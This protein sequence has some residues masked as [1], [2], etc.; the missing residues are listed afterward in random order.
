MTGSDPGGVA[1]AGAPVDAGAPADAGTGAQQPSG[2][3]PVARRVHRFLVPG[4]LVLATVLGIA[5]TFAI[6][7][8]RQALNT[9]NWSS[10]SS[11]ILQDKKVQTALSA[12][13]VHELFANVDVS[14]QLQ[15]V[16]PKQLQPLSGPAA[17]GLQQLAGQL[18]P[19]VL[20]S[21][22]VQG[23]WVQAN[24]AAHRELLRVLN[25]GGPVV[26]TRSGVVSL[27]LH[28]LV[29][30]LAAAVGLSSQVAAVQSKLQGST[31]ATVRAAAQQKLGVTLPPAS[32]QLVIMRSNEL[33]SA[34]DIAN[35]VKSLAIVLPA[36]AIGLFALA[37]Y[38]A[39]GRRRHTLRTTGWC[40]V[41]IGVALLLIRRVAGDAVVNGLVKIP[42]NKP[43]AH[44]VWNIG[45]SLLRDIA[46]AMIAYGIV[47][48]A[49]AWLA[50][51][52]RPGHRDPK[53]P[54][55]I[56]AR[57]SRG[58]LLDRR[59]PV[60]AARADRSDTGIPE[61]RLGA[62]VR[63]AARVRRHDA[64]TPDRTRV[65]W[66][67]ARPIATRLPRA[68]SRSP[69]TQDST[70]ASTPGDRRGSRR[71]TGG[72]RRACSVQRA[73][74]HAGAI[75]SAQIQ[76][77]ADRWGV[78]SR[79]G[80]H[81]EQRHLTERKAMAMAT[82]TR[83]TA[84]L[85]GR[86]AGAAVPHLSVAE[87]VARGKAARKE[88]PRAG[89]ALFEPLST[90]ADPVELLERQAKTRVP[91]LVPIRYGR[92][93]VSPFTFYRG[94]ASIMAHDLAATPRSG[95]IVQCCGDAHLSNFGVFASPERALVFDVNDF[96]ETL[97]GPW[98]WDVKR[99]AVSM[100][101]AARSNGFPAKEQDQIVLDTVGRYRTAMAE[102][103]GMK[104]LEVWYSHLDIDS[105]LQEFG[106][107][108]KPKL[109]KRA[110]KGLGKARTKD[111]MTAFSKLTHVVDG[112]ARI[113]DQSPLIVPIEQLA[114]AGE[115]RDQIFDELRQVLRGYRETLEFDRRVLLEEFEL[116]D[117]ARK[118]VGVGSVGTRAWIALLLG[119][120]GQDPLFLQMKEAEASVLEEFLGPS[121][122]SNHGERVVVGQRLMQAS[123]DIFLGWLHIDSGLDGKAR[124]FYG[125][126]L[127]DWKGSAEIEQMVPK[128]MAAYGKLCGWTLARA[129]ARS[130]D[131]IAI[132]SYLGTSDSF[133]RAIVEFSKAYA[134]QNERDYQELAAAVKSG[135]IKAETGL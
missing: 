68:P 132:A 104:S 31:G 76:R 113:V 117:F 69:R 130:G 74:R 19:R 70:L 89:H 12:Y 83:K 125:R 66:N 99:L 9:S 112:K 133:D 91:E 79:E 61:H 134:D 25:G 67:P 13:L 87:R 119:R 32:G 17:A 97:P 62:F 8:N 28:T 73:R 98:E 33:K 81:H 56:I 2:A 51:P 106:S 44:E 49:S 27:D 111:S 101:I 40:F 94:A 105:A 85:R 95:L 54:G 110:Q 71:S 58:R 57:Q 53:G 6:W 72:P 121:E 22:V 86:K 65:P 50:G 109:V 103:A 124:D 11:K 7:V 77:R 1:D 123:S 5:A 39:R 82:T 20:A 16:L 96:D 21:P 48:V 135:R 42:S 29:S 93:L 55:A 64:P 88:V 23:A 75:G 116:T 115:G 102:F 108:Y 126:Q 59:R 127:K 129:H 60:G 84:A 38:L 128:G 26:S 118:V 36:L 131:R 122:F 80:T 107:Q 34:Q 100:L 90:R 35:A 3:E 24:I 45:T 92:M 41:L 14:A 47:I 52:T 10:T 120:D 18:A 78:R 37:V 46:V 43:A 15:T 30:Q 4:L 63:R 114:P